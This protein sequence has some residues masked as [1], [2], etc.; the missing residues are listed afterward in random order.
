MN[1]RRENI[2]F[3]EE[4]MKNKETAVDLSTYALLALCYNFIGCIILHNCLIIH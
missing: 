2:T 3:A 4:E 1:K